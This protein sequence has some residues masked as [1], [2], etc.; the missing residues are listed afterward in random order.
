[1]GTS[2]AVGD[3]G[4]C[5]GVRVPSHGVAQNCSYFR[6]HLVRR[7]LYHRAHC[8]TPQHTA[9]HRNTLQRSATR[10]HL[11]VLSRGVAQNC[12]C[13]HLHLVWRPFSIKHTA[14]HCNTQQHAGTLE[15][16]RAGSPIIVAVFVYTCWCDPQQ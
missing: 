13:F 4:T 15:C 3:V 7:T 5:G 6:L 10:Q 9:T 1:M 8:N 16:R 14:T 2:Q 12:G 11:R